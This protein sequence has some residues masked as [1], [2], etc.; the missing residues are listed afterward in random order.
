MGKPILIVFKDYYN[1][2]RFLMTG[3]KK[4]K[5]YHSYFEEYQE[6]GSVGILS[7]NFISVSG[8]KMNQIL[9]KTISKYMKGKKIG[10]INTILER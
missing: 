6:G 10:N 4:N 8:K 2:G 1:Q 9:L 5:K 3:S 7:C